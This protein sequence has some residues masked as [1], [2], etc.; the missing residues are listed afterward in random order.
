M[1]QQIN[2]FNPAF[3]TTRKQFTAQ[4]LATLL[5]AI[6]VTIC[7]AAVIG[8]RGVAKL[9]RSVASG[10]ALLD[11]Q[12]AA[13]AE[14]IAGLA[15]RQKDPGLDAQL[16]QMQAEIASLREADSILR[17]GQ[18]GNH[19]GYAGYF[20]A[21]AQQ[22]VPGVWLTGLRIA[23]AGH[24]IEVRGRALQAAAI[25]GYIAQLQDRPAF[26]GKTFAALS[27]AP[28][29]A[30]D[31]PPAGTPVGTP[32]EPPASPRFVEFTLQSRVE[33]AP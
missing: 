18:I 14:T 12:Q 20:R 27:I 16:V 5:G 10:K 28:P 13:Q 2:L 1:S 7:I 31:V 4:L 11:Q 32:G 15:P 9:E 30:P 19:A 22:T 3:R 23:G 17:A 8:H 33:Q 6:V 25:P 24:D 21:F 26:R 29:A